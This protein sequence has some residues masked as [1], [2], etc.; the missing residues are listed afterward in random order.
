MHVISTMDGF[1]N[2]IS[3]YFIPHVISTMDGFNNAIS[4]HI[5]LHVIFNYG[6]F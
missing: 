5:I 3:I 1:N 2:A 4:L 6:W